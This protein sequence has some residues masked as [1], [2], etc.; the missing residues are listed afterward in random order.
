MSR[1]SVMGRM[2]AVSTACAPARFEVVCKR[3]IGRSPWADGHELERR[4]E[5]RHLHP[6]ESNQHSLAGHE[7]KVGNRLER[8][9]HLHLD[10]PGGNRSIGGKRTGF[11][12]S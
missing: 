7:G 12:R 11:R 1:N 6:A 8:P 9:G 4:V 2:M 3:G 5:R 10:E